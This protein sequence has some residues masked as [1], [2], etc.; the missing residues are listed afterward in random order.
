MKADEI[1]TTLRRA[2]NK[3]KASIINTVKFGWLSI[4]VSHVG[5]SV[6]WC[7]RSKSG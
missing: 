3:V 6:H 4:A 2:K 1:F 5:V 7:E